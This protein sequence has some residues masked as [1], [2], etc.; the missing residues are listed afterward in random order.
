MAVVKTA[1]SLQEELY[2][3]LEN[4]AE[5]LKMPRSRLYSLAL[6]EYAER[7]RRQ[8]LQ[9]QMNAAYSDGLD[10]EEQELLTK[11]RQSFRRLLEGEE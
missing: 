4:L 9:E 6:E 5:E 8:K 7:Y 1:V 2:E 3:K 11:M 10:E